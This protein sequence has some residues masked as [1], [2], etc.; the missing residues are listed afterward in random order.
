[1]WEDEEE[2]EEEEE[3]RP[4]TSAAVADS[5]VQLRLVGDLQ[6]KEAVVMER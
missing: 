1:L 5:T 3:E 6:G 4:P 2:E